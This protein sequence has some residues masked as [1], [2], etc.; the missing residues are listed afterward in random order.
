MQGAAMRTDAVASLV[1]FLLRLSVAHP[2]GAELG[3]MFKCNG[4]ISET[5]VSEGTERVQDATEVR[6]GVGGVANCRALDWVVSQ[7]EMIC[8]FR[9]ME[10][11]AG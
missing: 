1:P 2:P 10:E 6:H 7:A 3:T 5:R 11:R 8:A 9:Q 4:G